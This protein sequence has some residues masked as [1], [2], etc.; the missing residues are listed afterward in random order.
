VGGKEPAT[1]NKLRSAIID[2]FESAT[3]SI[4]QKTA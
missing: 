1:L 2:E 4:L 3:D